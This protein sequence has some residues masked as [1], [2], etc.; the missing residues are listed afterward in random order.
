M[1]IVLAAKPGADQPWVADA[2]ID[3]ARQT[4]AS[5]AVVAVDAVELER[6]AAAP[7][8]V[9]ADRAEEAVAAAAQR[10]AGAGIEVTTTVLPGRPLEGILGFAESEAADLVVVGSSG[11][12]AVA[13]RL[14]GSVPLELIKKSARPVLVITHP[15][16]G[17]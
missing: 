6:L 2:V 8:S 13:Q 5:V 14:L 12:P 10:I 4:G 3:L 15:H 9:S 1:R 16:R 11:R 7:R 17:S